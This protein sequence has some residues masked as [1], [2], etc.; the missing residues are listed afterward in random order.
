MNIIFKTRINHFDNKMCN[1]I[2]K[3]GALHNDP[4]IFFTMRWTH[5]DG[6][7]LSDGQRLSSNQLVPT[8]I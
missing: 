5:V 1:M 7:M 2:F 8:M 4:D 3:E 6:D